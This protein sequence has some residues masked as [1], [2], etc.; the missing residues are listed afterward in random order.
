MNKVQ[1]QET[2][3]S[4][5]PVYHKTTKASH[6]KNLETGEW[7]KFPE[8]QKTIFH[9]ML[10]RYKFF[11]SQGKDYFDNQEDIAFA[12]SCARRSVFS[13]IKLLS[14]CGY[15]TIKGKLTFQHRSNSYVFDKEL[16]LAILDKDKKV[17]DSFSTNIIGSSKLDK[18]KKVVI[19]KPVYQPPTPSLEDIDDPF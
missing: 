10:D 2:T 8:G 9:Y 17:I 13:T 12:C 6:I 19:N 5:F 1:S 14:D 4:Y 11:K 3:D 7:V 18:P 15:L 16:Q